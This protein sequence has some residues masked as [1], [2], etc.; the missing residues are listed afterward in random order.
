MPGGSAPSSSS[1]SAAEA[2]AAAAAAAKPPLGR[3]V[4]AQAKMA[5]SLDT[6]YSSGRSL[7]STCVRQAGVPARTGQA[8]GRWGGVLGHG[9]QQ[10]QVLA[11]TRG[12]LLIH[13]RAPPYQPRRGQRQEKAAGG[14]SAGAVAPFFASPPSPPP[15]PAH[16]AHLRRLSHRDAA[17]ED[18]DDAVAVAREHRRLV[19]L[20]RVEREHAR[21]NLLAGNGQE[22]PA[23]RPVERQ[24]VGVALAVRAVQL[25]RAHLLLKARRLPHL[26]GRGRRERPSTEVTWQEDGKIMGVESHCGAGGRL[27]PGQVPA[28]V[29]DPRSRLWPGHVPAPV[30]DPGS[31][32]WPGHLP[33][34]V[35][36]PGSR[37][38]PWHLPAPVQDPGRRFWP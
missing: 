35:Q 29:Q 9:V 36:D 20:V 19:A 32:L 10:Q 3:G 6:V 25:H 18:A 27:W 11:L 26:A 23:R 5:P 30:Q 7:P 21:D 8:H 15:L 4:Y 2:A 14:V 17:E 13:A 34:P 24:H 28:P 37:F 38:W 16:A 12:S 31:R 22:A 33:A 1:P